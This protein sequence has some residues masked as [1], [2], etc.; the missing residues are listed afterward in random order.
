MEGGTVFLVMKVDLEVRVTVSRNEPLESLLDQKKDVLKESQSLPPSKEFDHA[1]SLFKEE[2]TVNICPYR[3][4][5][6]PKNEIG[7]QI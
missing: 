3:Y 4:S 6:F 2:A 1:I 7:K 5:F